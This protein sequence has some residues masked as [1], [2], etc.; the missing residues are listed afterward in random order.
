MPLNGAWQSLQ[1]GGEGTLRKVRRSLSSPRCSPVRSARH[2][3][4]G[5]LSGTAAV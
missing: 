3:S 1:R 4:S 2:T 5:S